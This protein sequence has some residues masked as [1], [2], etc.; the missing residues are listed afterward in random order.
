MPPLPRPLLAA[1][2]FLRD[3]DVYHLHGYG[4][5]FV[6]AAFALL[7]DPRRTVFTSHGLPYTARRSRGPLGALYRGYDRLVGSRVVRQSR[8]LTAVSSAAAEE[9]RAT[10]GRE[11]TVVPNGFAPIVPAPRCS[12]AL[13]AEVAKGRFLLCVG[14]IEPLKGFDYAVRALRRLVDDGNDLRMIV[15]GGDNTGRA[16]L[17]DAIARS[18]LGARVSLAGPLA[19]PELAS[20]YGRAAVCVVASLAESFSLVTLEAMSAGVP[21]ALSAVGGMLDIGRDGE[22]AVFFAPTDVDGIARAVARIEREPGLRER[23]IA[24]GRATVARYAWPRVAEAYEAVYA[25]VGET[26][27][28]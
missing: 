11:A 26:D 8:A 5:A 13:E 27:R 15:A 17:E 6:D 19:R 12:D 20:L 7:A 2:P 28:A 25:R 22:N 14:R 18:E 10:Y 9:L 23:L 24:G 4:M 21:C 1:R 3:R 16:A